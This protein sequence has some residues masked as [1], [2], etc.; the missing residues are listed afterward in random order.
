MITTDPRTMNLVALG[1]AKVTY[2][3]LQILRRH[4]GNDLELALIGFAV[5]MRTRRDLFQIVEKHGLNDDTIAEISSE[6]G[7]YTS[8][9]E[10]HRYT[11]INRATVRRK[12]DRLQTLNIVEKIEGDKWHLV[13][14][15]HGEKA[16]PAIMLRDLLQNYMAI[17]NKLESLLPE[18]MHPIMGTTL[19]ELGSLEAKALLDDEVASKI[20]RKLE[21]KH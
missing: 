21:V 4:L 1:M 7:F 18:E 12:L 6:Q 20:T 10:I 15:S 17:T 3:A 14:F 11:G 16:R 19:E 13:D 2:G 5:V 9:N 8:I